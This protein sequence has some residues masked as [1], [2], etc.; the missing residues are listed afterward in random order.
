LTLLLSRVAEAAGT[1][2]LIRGGRVDV[3]RTQQLWLIRHGETEWSAAGR[4]TGLTDLPLTPR[5]ER[6]VEG[7]RRR[8]R[9]REFALVLSSPLRRA[10]D[11]CAFAGFGD[12]AVVDADLCEWD[13]GAYEGR[14]TAQIRAEVPGWDLWSAG[15]PGG[16]TVAQVGLRAD[17]VIARVQRE[18]G[19]VALFAHAHLLRVFTAR[20]L[21]MDPALG[22]WFALDAASVSVVGHEHEHHVMWLWNDVSHLAPEIELPHEHRH[23]A[24]GA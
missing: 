22:R 16:E 1:A 12:R 18:S 4:H 5:G 2:E 3:P 8:L 9:G 21:G 20:W 17:R 11:T 6:Q 7:L 13:Y 19:D 23:E 24:I 15:V 14:T 10:H